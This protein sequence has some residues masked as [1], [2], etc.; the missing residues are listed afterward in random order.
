M[1]K[2]PEW[3]KTKPLMGKISYVLALCCLAIAT[4]IALIIGQSDPRAYQVIALFLAYIIFSGISLLVDIA[5]K[6]KEG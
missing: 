5:N 2:I 3:I 1:R 4:L 6:N